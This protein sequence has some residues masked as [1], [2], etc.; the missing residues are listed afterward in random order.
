MA[1]YYKIDLD[2]AIT[3]ETLKQQMKKYVEDHNGYT[4]NLK[5]DPESIGIEGTN[6]VNTKKH[7]HFVA[8]IVSV[9]EILTT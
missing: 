4:H 1:V 3:S 7:K 9:L 2:M 5:I 6:D 8:N